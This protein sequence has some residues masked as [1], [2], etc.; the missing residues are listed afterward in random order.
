MHIIPSGLFHP[1]AI[2]NNMAHQFKSGKKPTTYVRIKVF[3]LLLGCLSV[4]ALYYVYILIFATNAQVVINPD[5]SVANSLQF[6]ADTAK[7]LERV[8]MLVSE[9]DRETS[10]MRDARLVV[11][12]DEVVE[13]IGRLMTEATSVEGK[14]SYLSRDHYH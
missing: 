2:A 9:I 7:A 10:L 1:A 14:K 8:Q 5:F 11:K 4:F 6:E 13:N 3:S 12:E